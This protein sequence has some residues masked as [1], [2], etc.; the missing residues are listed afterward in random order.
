M[1]KGHELINSMIGKNS[2]HKSLLGSFNIFKSI[3]IPPQ[4]KNITTKDKGNNIPK[5][6]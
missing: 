1:L 2:P 6:I 3:K 4:I 5:H